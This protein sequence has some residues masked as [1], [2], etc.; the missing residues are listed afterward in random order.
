MKGSRISARVRPYSVLAAAAFVA[1][2]LAFSV[3]QLKPPRVSFSWQPLG[4]RGYLPAE[5]VRP[6]PEL[7][8]VFV[9][10]P[11]CTWSN[12]ELLPELVETAKLVLRGRADSLGWSFAA[13]AVVKSTSTEGGSRYLDRFGRFDE[14]T[15]GRG[16]TNIGL[17]KYVHGTFP[18]RAATPQVLVLRRNVEFGPPRGITDEQV[19]IRRIGFKP[20][21]DWVKLGVP[22]P[23]SSPDSSEP[24]QRSDRTGSDL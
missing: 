21:E 18:G 23:L 3:G 16:W 7:A 5:G 20:I 8:F 15:L 2:W 4:T 11:T 9:G 22:L 17:L 19:L 1:S 6:G 13:I 24:H 10:S 12:V 14:I